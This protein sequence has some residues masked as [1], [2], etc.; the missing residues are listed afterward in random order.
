[1]EEFSLI[2]HFDE[3]IA[4]IENALDTEYFLQIMQTNQMTKKDGLYRNKMRS[5]RTSERDKK[6][7]TALIWAVEHY[8]D[9]LYDVLK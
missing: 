3:T 4:I 6:G 7:K 1:M 2:Y 8:Q 9:I 5:F